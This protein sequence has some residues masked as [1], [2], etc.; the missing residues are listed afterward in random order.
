M[1]NLLSIL[2]LLFLPFGSRSQNVSDLDG[3]LSE[4][5]IKK[6]EVRCSKIQSE[7]DII[8]QLYFYSNASDE[9]QS[10]NANQ[11]RTP[12]VFVSINRTDNTVV[13]KTTRLNDPQTRLF[14]NVFF[15]FLNVPLKE[16]ASI[17]PTVVTTL[18]QVEKELYRRHDALE[19]RRIEDEQYDSFDPRAVFL[20]WTF[21]WILVVFGV[22]FLIRLARIKNKHEAR[23]FYGISRL[24][25]WL[26]IVLGLVVLIGGSYFIMDFVAYG[27]GFAR[28]LFWLAFLPILIFLTFLITVIMDLR[29]LGEHDS[30]EANL[31]L[32]QMLWLIRPSANTEHLMEATF[33]ELVIQNKINLETESEE[34]HHRLVNEYYVSPGG[35]FEPKQNFRKDEASFFEELLQE[36]EQLEP[37]L[38]RIYNLYGN[39][40]TYRKDG[41]LRQL[42]R[43]GL[44]SKVGY[45][46]NAPMLT[47]KGKA[48]KEQLSKAEQEQAQLIAL[49]I[50]F[51]DEIGTILPKLTPQVLLIE[52]FERQLTHFYNALVDMGFLDQ[53]LT[54]PIGFLFH[55]DFSLRTFN[56]KL[57]SAYASMVVREGSDDDGD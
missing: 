29:H 52:D 42:F 57:R 15:Q 46:L 2:I 40:L 25:M 23:S 4:Q 9:P 27:A 30:E 43:S 5:E 7:H 10:P 54:L 48:L 17:F 50:Q 13:V 35:N 36:K 32:G 18:D 53:A 55:P 19:Q 31:T 51:P 49:G 56:L 41:V 6:L 11:S 20:L 45:L 37:Y 47:A 38:H 34:I 28:F 3:I 16:G 39:F 24:P 33:Y 44:L 1:Q 14:E 26:T 12:R 22:Y 8:L 21:F